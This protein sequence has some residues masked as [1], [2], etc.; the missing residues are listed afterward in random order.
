MCQQRPVANAARTSLKQP[1]LIFV[2]IDDKSE[3]SVSVICE[4]RPTCAVVNDE[5]SR[6]F[7]HWRPSP[8]ATGPGSPPSCTTR[9]RPRRR[10]CPALG[11]ARH[12]GWSGGRTP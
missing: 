3:T 10:G 2:V 6:E 8:P 4:N 1:V 7:T 11:P 12:Q 5:V 9:R